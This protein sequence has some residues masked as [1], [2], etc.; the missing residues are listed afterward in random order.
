MQRAKRQPACDAAYPNLTEGSSI[1]MRHDEI[2]SRLER[3]RCFRAA[4]EESQAAV[5]TA[6]ISIDGC[7]IWNCLRGGL[8]GFLA[9]GVLVPIGEVVILTLLQNRIVGMYM[10]I[11]DR[12]SAGPGV[13]PD[14]GH[15]RGNRDSLQMDCVRWNGS[16]LRIMVC[17]AVAGFLDPRT[18]FKAVAGQ[19]RHV[20]RQCDA[21]H[22]RLRL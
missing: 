15:T 18:S 13:K 20:V 16:H 19:R 21:V 6:K 22:G 10:K 14:I 2:T 3:G 1:Y 17:P 4:G 9:I 7:V 11:S 8:L 12:R 5:G